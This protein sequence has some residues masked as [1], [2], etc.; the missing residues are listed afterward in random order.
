VDQELEEGLRSIAA[1]IRD[2]DGQVIAAVNISTHAGRRTLAAIV[3][4]FLQPLL[5]TSRRIE[6]DLARSRVP[7]AGGTGGVVPPG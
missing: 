7:V 1:P 6:V 5:T 2:A 3:E 4:E